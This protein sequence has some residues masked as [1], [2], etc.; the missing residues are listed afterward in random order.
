MKPLFRLTLLLGVSAPFRR[1]P[2][3][4]LRR[5]GRPCLMALLLLACASGSG[6]RATKHV[7]RLSQPHMKPIAHRV[8]TLDAAYESSDGRLWLHALGRLAGA[9]KPAPLTVVLPPPHVHAPRPV[10]QRIAL[11]TSAV[12]PGWEP[13]NS[14]A[15]N[16][17][18][19]PVGPPLI[20]TGAGTYE[21]HRLLPSAGNRRELRLVR[22]PGTV[23]EWEVLH[24]ALDPVT[25]E[26]SFTVFEVRPQQSQVRHRAALALVPLAMA[27]DVV[28]VGAMVSGPLVFGAAC[29]YAGRPDGI[30]LVPQMEPWKQLSNR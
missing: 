5:A 3:L 19:I 1:S 4:H 29:V 9:A 28:A 15:A 26:C 16:W 21:W 2:V 22:R 10:A 30:A 20:F 12:R 18:P 13:A 24:L 14:S 6:C 23:G 7:V 25:Q 11:P 27:S 8:Q 17:R